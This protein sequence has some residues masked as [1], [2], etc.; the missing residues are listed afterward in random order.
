MTESKEKSPT[1]QL[2]DALRK[3]IPPERR[4]GP[5]GKELVYACRK[6]DRRV[7][8]YDEKY[9]DEHAV[10]CDCEDDSP[11]M[12]RIRDRESMQ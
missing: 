11:P 12:R 3:A 2:G 4:S 6:C 1:A 5:K 7:T 10:F 9:N 8:I